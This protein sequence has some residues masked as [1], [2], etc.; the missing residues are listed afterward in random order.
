MKKVG[1][2]TMHRVL[3]YGSAL[4]AYT[5]QEAIKRLGF[6]VEIIDYHFPN[7]YHRRYVKKSRIKKVLSFVLHLFRGFPLKRKAVFFDAF[8]DKYFKLSAPFLSP[9]ELKENFPVYDIYVAGS[10]QI[11]NFRNTFDDYSFLLPFVPGDKR[12]ISYASSFANIEIPDI[13]KTN[14]SSY[15]AEFSFISVR[16]YNSQRLIRSLI[17]RHAEI[18][19]DPTLLLQRRDYE[20]IASNS[21]VKID[22]AYIL[23]YVLQYAYNPYPFVTEFIKKLYKQTGMHIVLLDFSS[24]QFLGVRDVTN[25]H[26]A[27]GPSEFLWLFLNASLVV[28]TSF[29][30]TAFAINFERPFFAIIDDKSKADD[31][32]FNLL[33]LCNCTDRAVQKN[34]NL[35]AE[36]DIQMDFEPVTKELAKVRHHSVS[37]LKKL[38]VE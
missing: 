27:V 7:N 32:I 9:D 29:H 33:T 26:D 6:E 21:T 1:I 31:R 36:F 19:L 18:C 13:Y 4:Q 15:L 34:S 3:N 20:T 14:Y 28:T 24:K 5:T 25:L 11:W 35:N 22:Q 12:K 10:D 38:L 16:E 8:Y 2:L 37:F 17:D 23:V 30:G